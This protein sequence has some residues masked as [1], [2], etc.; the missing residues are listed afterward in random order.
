MQEI[1]ER[2]V[3]AAQLD[4]ELL[5]EAISA[6]R[7]RSTRLPKEMAPLLWKARVRVIGDMVVVA[8]ELEIDK[9]RAPTEAVNVGTAPPSELCSCSLEAVR[10]E[11]CRA[12]VGFTESGFLICEIPMVMAEP[13]A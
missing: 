2:P 10:I 7:V 12:A 9:E 4:A 6:G 5:E 3:I 1:E 13:W 8:E 11:I